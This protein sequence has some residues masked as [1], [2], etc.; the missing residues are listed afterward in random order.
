MERIVFSSNRP[1]VQPIGLWRI[2]AGAIE[3]AAI[4]NVD[5]G[6]LSCSFEIEL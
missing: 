1:P 6:D 3:R 4:S 5:S 2:T